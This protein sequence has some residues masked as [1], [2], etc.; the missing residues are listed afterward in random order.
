MT[1]FQ[2]ANV[3]DV[4]VL[5]TKHVALDKDNSLDLTIRP[6]WNSVTSCDVRVRS[7]TGGLRM[8][9]TE[10]KFLDDTRE[11]VKP[12][13]P[14]AFFFGAIAEG[15]TVTVRY[16][17]SIE[18]DLGDVSAKVE[19]TYVTEAGETYYLAK[20][21]VIPVS[22][23]VGVNVQDVFK[24]DALFSRFN[25]STANFSPLRLYKSEL[26]ESALFSSEFGFPPT[27]TITVFPKQPATLLYKIKRK[28]GTKAA[29]AADKT[30]YLKLHYS[31][32]QTEVEDMIQ[33]SVQEGLAETP[34]SRY[35][36]LLAARVLQETKKGL[37][38]H[39]LERAALLGEVSTAFLEGAPWTQHFAGLGTVPGTRD[40]A[41]VKL[42]EYLD[43][44]QQQHRR[45]SIP[46]AAPAEPSTILIPVDI[47]S[48]FVVHT[49]D[50][51]VDR[52]GLDHLQGAGAGAPAASVNQILT[53]TLHLKWTRVWDT[54]ATHTDDGEFSYEV[55]AP[56][57]SWILGGR[58]K[59]HFVI[60][61]GSSPADMSSTPETEAE[62][63]LMLIPQREGY[64][65]YPSVEIKEV[66]P[67]GA[68]AGSASCE[69]DWRNL[70]ETVRV[71]SER[72]GVTVSLDA[73][74]P[75]G[76][77]LVFDNERM[78]RQTGRIVA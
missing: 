6:G 37:Q 20:S 24:H 74:G 60:P 73:S 47:P 16:P 43:E 76:G 18:Q 2:G 7:T 25:V 41:A 19:V 30:L 42:A 69:V 13:E 46:S 28:L 53:A 33:E 56:G 14:G 66:P 12:P 51:R 21:I 67:E 1:L 3:L 17:Y 35:S 64:L 54:D 57:E 4:Q 50:M 31:V 23:A 61:G 11:F 72:K 45:L 63:P 34:L 36:R 75:G 10:A 38:M 48:L 9:T 77:P 15:E 32:L 49:A 27:N 65:P 68:E 55:T 71:V 26:L 52:S 58:R 40:D 29:K 70:G 44:W 78:E 39:D 22:L 59:G 5:A 62:I 8:L